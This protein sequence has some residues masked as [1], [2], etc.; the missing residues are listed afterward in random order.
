MD[1]RLDHDS[2]DAALGR[3]GA[4]WTAAQSHGLLTGRL[5]VAGHDAGPTWLQQVLEDVDLSN[6][7]R[8][9]CEGLLAAAFELAHRQLAERLS[10]FEPLLPDDDHDVAVRATGLAHWCEGFLHGLVSARADQALKER[11]AAE[12]LADIIKDMLQITRAGIDPE[13]DEESSEEAL[14]ELVEYVRVAAQLAYEELAD[15]RA[16]ENSSENAE[17]AP[18]TLH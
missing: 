1:S 8:S 6:A 9:E 4:G 10:A 7:L 11:L 17:P 3:C 2:L 5:A 15:I 13:D 16:V 12:P 14:T 18:D